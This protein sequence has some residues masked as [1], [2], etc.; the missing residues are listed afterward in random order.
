MTDS[1]TPVATWALRAHAVFD[2]IWWIALMNLLWWVFAVA[3]LIVVGVV[4]ASVAAAGLIRRRLRGE[5]FPV[6][7]TFAAEWRREL[8]RSNAA[9]GVGAVVTALLAVNVV[10]R[11]GAGAIAEPLG[12][13]SV[14]ALVAAFAITAVAVPMYAHYD[15]P[16]RAYL[17]T[18]GR[19]AARNVLHVVLLLL[20]AVAVAGV[21]SILPGVVPFF[22]VGA[23]LTLSTVLCIAFFTANDRALAER[24]AAASTA[25]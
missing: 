20:G 6:L 23:W 19:W 8:W 24:E 7:R 22:A 11:L 21:G 4:P 3:G 15:L 18:A 25:P 17:F 1:A 2:W 14:A 10:G 12:I 13:L 16:L 9:V 5:V